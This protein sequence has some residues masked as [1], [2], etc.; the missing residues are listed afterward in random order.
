[1]NKAVISGDVISSTSLTDDDRELLENSFQKLLKELSK[2][3]NVYGRIIKG[4]YIECV[5]PEPQNALRVALAVKSFVKAI[6]LSNNSLYKN[7]NKIKL[8]K[9]HGIRLAIGYGEL[10]RFDREKGIIDGEAIYLSG[11]LINEFSTHNKKRIVIKNTLNFVS[12]E[13]ELDKVFDPLFS[14]LDVLISKATSRQSEVLYLKLLYNSED[15]IAKKLKISQSV[16]NQHS[17]SLGWNSIEK[18]VDYFN[19]VISN[20]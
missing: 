18:A 9:T 3:F 13:E 5:I 8:F 17:T 2:E 12:N 6:P 10:T 14:L 15:T 20:Y 11:R 16:V 19:K 1:M 7:N 4:D